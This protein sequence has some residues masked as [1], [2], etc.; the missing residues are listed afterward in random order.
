MFFVSGGTF[1]MALNKNDKNTINNMYDQAT[2]RSLEYGYFLLRVT[3]IEQYDVDPVMQLMHDIE[4][5][6]ATVNQLVSC[7]DFWV[8]VINLDCLCNGEL[9]SPFPLRTPLGTPDITDYLDAS[10]P[11]LNEGLR[12]LIERHKSAGTL[13]DFAKYFLQKYADGFA[14][15]FS[16]NPRYVRDL[17]FTVTEFYIDDESAGLKAHHSNGKTSTF[18]RT[19]SNTSGMNLAPGD[20][21]GYFVGELSKMR[22]E[23]LI[24]GKPMYEAKL[25]G[26]YNSN[27]EWKPIVYTG[28]SDIP[29]AAAHKFSSDRD[30][31]GILF[32]MYTTGFPVVEFVMKT[33][34][35]LPSQTTKLDNGVNLYK[36]KTEHDELKNEYIY[37]GWLRL[38]DITEEAVLNGIDT[39]RLTLEG[40]TYSYG[41][42]TKWQ[43]KYKLYSNTSGVAT[44]TAEDIKNSNN[45]ISCITNSA[46]KD[47]LMAAVS[48]FNV[49][50]NSNNPIIAFVCYYTAIEALA[51]LL[52]EGLLD[53]SKFYKTKVT[54]LNEKEMLR[55]YDALYKT[56]YPSDIKKLLSNGY[57][58]IHESLNRSVK[59]AF[60]SVYGEDHKVYKAMSSN[61]DGLVRLRGSIVHDSYS[62]W[63][64]QQYER[65]LQNLGLIHDIAYDFISM[66]ALQ[67][68]KGSRPPGMSRRFKASMDASHPSTTLAVSS[69]KHLPN[70]TWDIRPDWL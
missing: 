30:A 57:F 14:D 1:K 52:A 55:E 36:I 19:G 34:I 61:K 20:G 8:L 47:S 33:K 24:N 42:E 29:Q 2:T 9:Y 62:E 56:H 65:A 35:E 43:L 51:R 6:N 70:E 49:G 44:P 45:L 10:L 68:P 31:Q 58:D 21:V 40:L 46:D 37:D 66:I 32:Y 15:F 27:G 28:D 26:K 4:K 7:E 50:S 59:S 60:S 64:R 18:K 53:A 23:W 3:G 22:K 5:G 39:I 16:I 54:K 25:M 69:L 12:Q 17:Q 41:A 48:W 11:L 67:V 13:M 63:N 38:E